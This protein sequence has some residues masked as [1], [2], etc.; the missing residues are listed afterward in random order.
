MKM[1]NKE[2]ELAYLKKSSYLCVKHGLK[3]GK[4]NGI[5]IRVIGIRN[6]LKYRSLRKELSPRD[7]FSCC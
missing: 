4:L 5:D 2:Q 1:R 3:Y 7:N 6:Y